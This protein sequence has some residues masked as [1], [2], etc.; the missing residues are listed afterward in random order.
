MCVWVCVFITCV[1]DRRDVCLRS[2]FLVQ[3]GTRAGAPAPL[4]QR[5]SEDLGPKK[6]SHQEKSLRYQQ[7]SAHLALKAD[8]TTCIAAMRASPD[9]VREVKRTWTNLG[10]IKDGGVMARKG[11]AADGDSARAT[12]RRKRRRRKTPPPR[13]STPPHLPQAARASPA[14]RSCSTCSPASSLSRCPTTRCVA[15]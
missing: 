15:F 10:Y 2:G 14:P 12:Q 8:L 7:A 1:S 13:T 4:G 6:E 9:A 11:A 3:H 5:A